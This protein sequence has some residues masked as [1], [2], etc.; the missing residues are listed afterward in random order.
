MH[1][2][3]GDSHKEAWTAKLLLLFVIAQHVTDVLAEKAFDALAKFLHAIDFALI[4]LP[5]YV[6]LRRER[7]NLLVHTIIPGDVSDQILE[8]RKRLHW[9]HGDWSIERQRIETRLAGQTWPAVDFRRARA[10]LAGLAVPAHGEIG[11][12]MRLNV[13]QRVEHNHTGR[14]RHLVFDQV[15]IAAVAAKDFESCVRHYC[16][17]S[18]IARRSEGIS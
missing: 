6:W 16:F 1:F 8:H 10:A 13:M 12:V 7:R 2:E 18:K 17:S 9:L 3:P 4:H 15:T 14:D 11:R 5:F